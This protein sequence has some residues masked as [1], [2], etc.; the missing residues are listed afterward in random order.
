MFKQKMTAL[1]LEMGQFSASTFFKKAKARNAA[2]Q[3]NEA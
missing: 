1:N 3:I 2:S